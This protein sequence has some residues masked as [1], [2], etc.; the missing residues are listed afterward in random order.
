MGSIMFTEFEIYC[1]FLTVD[2]LGSSSHLLY[3]CLVC[4][5]LSLQH[6]PSFPSTEVPLLGAFRGVALES[7]GSADGGS[8]QREHAAA[9]G[10]GMERGKAPTLHAG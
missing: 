1:L 7:S 8:H 10:L 5:F 4:A 6:I 2:E 9:A 3:F